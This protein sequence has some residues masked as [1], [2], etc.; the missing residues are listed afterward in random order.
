MEIW[1]LIFHS[2]LFFYVTRQ[3][4]ISS[5]FMNKGWGWV[6]LHHFFISLHISERV[7]SNDLIYLILFNSYLKMEVTRN[8]FLILSMVLLF[9]QSLYIL[10]FIIYTIF[11]RPIV[12]SI[13]PY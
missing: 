10:Y 13:W 2:L 7:L 6:K 9:I 12:I 8:R 5:N 3:L 11:R 4:I 1:I